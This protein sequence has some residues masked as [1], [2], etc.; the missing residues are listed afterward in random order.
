ME[1][2]FS[3]IS[4]TNYQSNN[5]SAQEFRLII[6]Q[7]LVDILITNNREANCEEEIDFLL[8]NSSNI[9]KIKF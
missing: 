5:P 9:S 7:I 4:G 1:N 2:L 6:I 3:Q 8:F